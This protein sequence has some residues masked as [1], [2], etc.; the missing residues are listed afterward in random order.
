[1]SIQQNWRNLYWYFRRNRTFYYYTSADVRNRCI[2]SNAVHAGWVPQRESSRQVARSWFKILS[3]Y[4]EVSRHM[5]L[6]LISIN[7]S[8]LDFTKAP[9][10]S[11]R[12]SPENSFFSKRWTSHMPWEYGTQE[13]RENITD[14]H[15]RCNAI[16]QKVETLERKV[17]KY[18]H[19][20]QQKTNRLAHLVTILGLLLIAIQFSI[21]W[22]AVLSCFDFKTSSTQ[23]I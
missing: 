4:L 23:L 13:I 7:V 21:N 16:I 6:N 20:M 8:T 15:V 19:E 12:V 10:K 9:C 22:N 2:A 5:A 3:H 14:L 11:T 18:Q 1:M 17:E